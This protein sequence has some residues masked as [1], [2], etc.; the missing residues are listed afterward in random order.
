MREEYKLKQLK[1]KRRGLIPALQENIREQAKT[2]ISILLD[3]DV[4]EYFKQ[5]AEKPGALPYQ[6]QINQ[7]LH[8]VME[9]RKV[10][11]PEKIDKQR[12]E[13]LKT[14][15]LQDK[16]FIRAIAKQMA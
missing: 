10:Y 6:T 9:D 13:T 8:Q 15:L 12:L 14:A 16:T 11:R 4:L 5:E 3:H 1:V 2:R 7:T